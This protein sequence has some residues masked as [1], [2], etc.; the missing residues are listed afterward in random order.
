MDLYIL[1]CQKNLDT[2]GL[3]LLANQFS[4]LY[5]S[6]TL[7]FYCVYANSPSSVNTSI[8]SNYSNISVNLIK[9]RDFLGNELFDRLMS[10][11]P[12]YEQTHGHSFGWFLQQIIKLYSPL[13][14]N[15]NVLVFD[16][17]SFPLSKLPTFTSATHL[18]IA[19]E[20]NTRYKKL[21]ELVTGSYDKPVTTHIAQH[22]FFSFSHITKLTLAINNISPKSNLDWAE[23]LASECSVDSRLVLSE[24]ELYARF[25][26]SRMSNLTLSPILL[27]RHGSIAFKVIGKYISLKLYRLYSVDI[28]AFEQWS[29]PRHLTELILIPLRKIFS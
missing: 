28:I 23:I 22:M 29:R 11:A 15:R 24:Y 2:S 8:N 3:T 4:R 19:Y 21:I 7:K 25:V 27:A 1:T 20:H 18:P 12:M 6:Y 5:P 26:I 17:D 10:Y 16:S 13:V 14:L 9:D